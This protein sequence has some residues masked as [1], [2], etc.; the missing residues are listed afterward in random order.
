MASRSG[1]PLLKLTLEP[2]LLDFSLQQILGSDIARVIVFDGS[3]Y[4]DRPPS[5]VQN[6]ILRFWSMS[7]WDLIGMYFKCSGTEWKFLS[8]TTEPDLAI[9]GVSLLSAIINGV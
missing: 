8:A 9:G 3:L 5:E 1:I 6:G 4:G 2:E 7:G